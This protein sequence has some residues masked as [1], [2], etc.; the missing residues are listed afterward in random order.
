MTATK[1]SKSNKLKYKYSYN[2]RFLGVFIYAEDSVRPYKI[3]F[4]TRS[5]LGLSV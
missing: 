1:I 4:S 2:K 5:L 3:R